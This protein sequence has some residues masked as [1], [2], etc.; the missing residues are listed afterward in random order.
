MFKSLRGN[1]LVS[2]THLREVS[3]FKSVILVMDHTPQGAMGVVI[4]QPMNVAIK[5]ALEKHFEMPDSDHSLFSGGPVEPSAMMVLHSDPD[6]GPEGAMVIPGV[7]AGTSADIFDDIAE[8]IRNPDVSLKFR[9]F[10]GY[11]GWS[12]G[13]LDSE[14]GRGDWYILDADASLVFSDNPYEVW[15]Q[16]MKQVHSQSG[17]IADLNQSHEWN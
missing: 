11:S 5:D 10:A 8:A 12:S 13:Q 2:A 9:M 7:Y 3:F 1:F 4:N 16:L 17:V 14:V 15:E 6:A